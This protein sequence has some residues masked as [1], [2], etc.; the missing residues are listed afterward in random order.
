MIFFT[1][2]ENGSYEKQ[3]FC[4]I[5]KKRFT[6]DNKKVRD[7]CYLTGKYRGATHNNCNMN[8][9]LS[10]NIPV[11]FHN[12]PTYDYHFIIKELTKEFEG[13][14]ECLGENTEKCITIS[15]PISKEI[16]KIDKDGNDK[17]VT[18]PYKLKFIGSFRFQLHYQVLLIIFLMDYI[19][20]N[21]QI[22]NLVLTI[23]KFKGIQSIFRCFK[24]NTDYN[25][26]FDKQII[27]RFSSTYKFCNG[28]LN[29]FILLLR[30]GVYPYEY[31][32]S[33]E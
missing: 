16:T 6:K 30:K 5:C 20:I 21:V 18:I 12:G 2:A 23:C 10:K 28:D 11:V 32:D 15:V 22:V 33:W 24:C 17:I 3:K 9:K 19:A 29:K 26:D 14:F 8:Y 27:N 1:D 25:N 13:Q 31:I 4:Y 7:Q